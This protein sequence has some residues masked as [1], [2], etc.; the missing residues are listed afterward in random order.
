M[1]DVMYGQWV[2][3][4]IFGFNFDTGQLWQFQSKN[5]FIIFS[6]Q[7]KWIRRVMTLLQCIVYEF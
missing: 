7:Q 6:N 2:F 5:Y 1:N 4:F 3:M